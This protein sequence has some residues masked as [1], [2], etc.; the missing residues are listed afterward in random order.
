[1]PSSSSLSG[2]TKWLR[3]DPWSDAFGD[4][5]EHHLGPA[6]SKAGI[7]IGELSDIIG[8]DWV[9]SL[10]GC[11]FEDFLTRDLDEFGNIVEDYLKRRGWNEKAH[12]KAYMTGLRTSVM[13]LYEVSGIKSGQSFLARDLFRGGEPVRISERTATRSLKQWDRI[14]VRVVEMRDKTVI[15]G[16]VLPFDHEL[17]QTLLT[18]LRRIQKRVA[19]DGAEVLRDLVPGIEPAEIDKALGSEEVLRL[20]S[21]LFS[22]YWL[23]DVLDRALNPQVPELRNSDGEE[24]V[25]LSL[26]Y[27]LLRG[28]TAKRVREAL[29]RLPDLRQESA[30]F[31]NWLASNGAP[32][33][34]TKSKAQSRLSFMSKME[35]GSIVLGTLE[36]KGKTLLLSVNSESRAE[37]GRA[38]LAPVLEGLV[39]A[40]LTERQDMAQAMADRPA[41]GTSAA[42]SGFPPEEERHIIHASLESHYRKQL[43]EPIPMLGDITPR[44]AAKTA[45]GR[46]KLV[47]WL[48]RLENHMA[49]HEPSGPMADYD[50]AWL[51]EELGVSDLR[52]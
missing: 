34:R 26:H 17:S 19:K 47:A 6:C 5:L 25:F 21:P 15:G 40:P 28:V 9:A 7:E 49:K 33:G 4:V 32:S 27:R 46:E 29:N 24:M 8:N 2:L 1:M 18:S 20:S 14:A 43:D 42:S 37:R 45:K 41:D 10:W 44:Q 11:A 16:G 23:N 35:D 36:L 31:W 3:R 12:N 39:G 22:T 51:W 13:S 50:V 38:M 48:K 52:R 30:T